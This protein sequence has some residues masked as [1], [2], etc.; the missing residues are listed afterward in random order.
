[1]LVLL[2]QFKERDQL[3]SIFKFWRNT[4]PKL[5]DICKHW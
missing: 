2:L 5:F 1:M 4:D 3:E